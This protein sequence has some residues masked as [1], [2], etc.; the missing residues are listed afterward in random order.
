M[1]DR[2]SSSS[3]RVSLIA[4]LSLSLSLPSASRSPYRLLKTFIIDFLF[5]EKKVRSPKRRAKQS[6]PAYILIDA[7][8]GKT[9]LAPPIAGIRDE[10]WHF[11]GVIY[12]V[13]AIFIA[14]ARLLISTFPLSTSP[15]SARI[16][17]NRGQW[18]PWTPVSMPRSLTLV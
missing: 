17:G 5:E 9:V 1:M 4:L 6:S 15:S 8:L 3:T 12:G 7:K 2:P 13:V 10:D 11:A 18:H 16:V 14:A